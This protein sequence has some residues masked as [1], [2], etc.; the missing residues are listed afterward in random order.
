MNSIKYI[1]GYL[2]WGRGLDSVEKMIFLFIILLMRVNLL[3]KM[4]VEILFYMRYCR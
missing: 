3:N 2:G 1:E 4:S